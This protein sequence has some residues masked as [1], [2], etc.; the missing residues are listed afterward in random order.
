MLVILLGLGLCTTAEAQFLKKLFGK[1]KREALELQAAQNRAKAAEKAR[2]DSLAQTIVYARPAHSGL[3][4]S[5]LG[6]QGVFDQLEQSF[7]TVQ[8]GK[9]V[10]RIYLLRNVG[11]E[12]LRIE[13]VTASCG[14]TVPAYPS[15]PIQP[16]GVGEIRVVMNTAGKIG[17]QQKHLFV[18]TNDPDNDGRFMLSLRGTVRGLPGPP[19]QR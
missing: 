15:E 19:P 12:P 8:Q 9:Q 14:C 16:G 4:S 2:Q 3:D 5:R 1:K 11:T 13:S 17:P 7:D 10:Q 6:P 18:Q